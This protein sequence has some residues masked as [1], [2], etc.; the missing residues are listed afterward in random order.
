M[1]A[2]LRAGNWTCGRFGKRSDGNEPMC[3][4]QRWSGL[5]WGPGN[6]QNLQFHQE[7]KRIPDKMSPVRRQRLHRQFKHCYGRTIVNAFTRH[8]EVAERNGSQSDDS[9][10][11]SYSHQWHRRLSFILK[12]FCPVTWVKL[13][14]STYI[15][16]GAWWNARHNPYSHHTITL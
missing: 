15:T 5:H 13:L 3:Q 8:Q 6:E 2:R 9:F 11:V 14:I 10:F 1:L 4:L 7:Y 16:S 12:C